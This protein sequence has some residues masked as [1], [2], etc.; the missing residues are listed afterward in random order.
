MTP[1]TA[2][3]CPEQLTWPGPGH[4]YKIAA[5]LQ[6]GTAAFLLTSDDK[7]LEKKPQTNPHL[8]KPSIKMNFNFGSKML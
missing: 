8:I 7:Q 4:I 3:A 2:S 1:N 5:E 6:A